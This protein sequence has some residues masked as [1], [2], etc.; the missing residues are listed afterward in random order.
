MSEVTLIALLKR[1]KD[2]SKEEF[3]AYWADVHAPLV[4]GTKSG[5]HAIHYERRPTL[6]DT[7]FD[8]VTIQTFSSYDDFVAH[9]GEA[10]F[11]QIADDL[12]KFLDVESMAWVVTGEPVIHR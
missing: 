2:M 12:P 5:S 7:D 6:G 8:G 3:N 4:L 9:I 10:D 11:Q 1:R